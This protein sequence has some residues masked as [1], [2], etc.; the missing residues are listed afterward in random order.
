MTE[1]TQ[2]APSPRPSQPVPMWILGVALFSLVLVVVLG[3]WL[4]SGV[5]PTSAAD[6]LLAQPAESPERF[7]AI[8]PF[9]LV[10]RSGRTVTHQDLRG[11]PWV[12]GFIF[13]RCT[14]P[15][16]KISGNM[17]LLSSK[18]DGVDARLVTISVDPE[19]DTPEVLAAYAKNLGAD[20]SRW[21]FLTG[22]PQAIQDVSVK[23]FQLPVEKD[24]AAPVGQLVT[25]R[26]VLVVVDADGFVRGYYD[27]EGEE[28]VAQAA[29]RA[30]YLARAAK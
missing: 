20:E 29:A 5:I 7:N 16:P 6:S 1:T 11:K 25:H 19:H 9:E 13:T 4:A 2:A 14:G 23:S 8:A 26:T 30:A 18:L 15:C 22:T 21:W 28:G 17:K 3:A 12:A 27:G 10:E 24:P